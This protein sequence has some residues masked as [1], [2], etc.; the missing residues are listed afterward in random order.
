MGNI[1]K[2]GHTGEDG[3]RAPTAIE[4][5]VAILYQLGECAHAT[6]TAYRRHCAGRLPIIQQAILILYTQLLRA[7]TNVPTKA[8]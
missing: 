1:E 8:A 6:G 4:V 5:G 7:A 3:D 2:I